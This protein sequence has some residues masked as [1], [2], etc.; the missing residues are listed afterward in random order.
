MKP[1][2]SAGFEGEPQFERVTLVVIHDHNIDRCIE[3]GGR[4]SW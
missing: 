3:L 4:T 1:A 2:Y